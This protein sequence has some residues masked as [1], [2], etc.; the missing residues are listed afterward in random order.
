MF[1]AHFGPGGFQRRRA[2]PQQAQQPPATPAAQLL[3][4]VPVV[5]LLLFTFL[6]MPSAP[7][8]PLLTLLVSS[9]LTGQSACLMGYALHQG[10]S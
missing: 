5:L 7:V 3:H 6:Q 1:R 4:L 10:F 8:G 9:P 2:G